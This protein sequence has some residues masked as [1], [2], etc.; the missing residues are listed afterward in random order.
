V[1]TLFVERSRSVGAGVA[2]KTAAAARVATLTLRNV[3][4]LGQLIE[5][6]AET[7]DYVFQELQADKESRT[8]VVSALPEQANQQSICVKPGSIL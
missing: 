7:G 5:L 4:V 3:D 2:A 8:G 1:V 6:R